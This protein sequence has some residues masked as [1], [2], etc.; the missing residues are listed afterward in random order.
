MTDINHTQFYVRPAPIGAATCE[1][2]TWTLA[3]PIRVALSAALDATCHVSSTGFVYTTGRT[4]H[5]AKL[6]NP[7]TANMQSSCLSSDTDVAAVLAKLRSQSSGHTFPI[8]D[9]YPS[10]GGNPC[11]KCA[12]RWD[13]YFDI[14]T[15]CP[16]NRV[17]TRKYRPGEL[18][19]YARAYAI[20]RRCRMSNK[21]R[22]SPWIQPRSDQMAG[23][24][25][26][27]MEH[28]ADMPMWKVILMRSRPAGPRA[29]ARVREALCTPGADRVNVDF[30]LPMFVLGS[31]FGGTRDEFFEV[32]TVLIRDAGPFYNTSPTLCQ[33]GFHLDDDTWY[34]TSATSLV[35][36]GRRPNCVAIPDVCSSCG[37]CH[38]E[39]RASECIKAGSRL[40][41]ETVVVRAY[42]DEVRDTERQAQWDEQNAIV[43]DLDDPEVVRLMKGRERQ[44]AHLERQRQF[45]E[46]EKT[47]GVID[48]RDPVQ[49]KGAAKKKK[50]K[51]KPQVHVRAEA[52]P[53]HIEVAAVVPEVHVAD[54]APRAVM[55]VEKEEICCLS[56]EEVQD[57]DACS[58]CMER[59][60]SHVL[61]P[62][63]HF[64][65][66]EDCV[67]GCTTCPLCRSDVMQVVR[68]YQ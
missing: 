53:E 50:K 64:Q 49:P 10:S 7:Q 19:G 40:V 54:Q 62:C 42:D 37:M 15:D 32:M 46:V 61:V 65:F 68:V 51:Q 23:A 44:R 11:V 39:I 45:K 2:E 16:S 25:W 13:T 22:F 30:D 67:R 43:L 55:C 21:Q 38:V 31:P 17:A 27:R 12:R 28:S 36:S 4:L 18:V 63:G 20:S 41:S 52:P 6:A 1:S 57:S 35:C 47:L 8:P 66:C 24:M 60:K 9:A 26:T 56:D 48:K 59:R 58:V 29:I 34:V 14:N 5:L 33:P 3:A